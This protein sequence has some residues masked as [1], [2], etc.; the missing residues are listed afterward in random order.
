[1]TEYKPKKLYTIGHNGHGGVNGLIEV[2]KKNQ[3]EMVIDVR[4]KA[5]SAH[6]GYRKNNLKNSLEVASIYYVHI[7]EVAPS[8][9]MRVWWNDILKKYLP[10][11]KKVPWEEWD[12]YIEKF[13]TPE[14]ELQVQS[15][16][17]YIKE[18]NITT[19]L[20]CAENN[21]DDCHRSIVA[22]MLLYSK[23][24]RDGKYILEDIDDYEDL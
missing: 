14:L 9:E 13:C 11:G 21:A 10:F 16:A 19:C 18:I 6:P 3:I 4:R 23:D 12:K 24:P 2:L 1:M 7:P 20:L 5:W 8:N 15:L 17:E 22:D